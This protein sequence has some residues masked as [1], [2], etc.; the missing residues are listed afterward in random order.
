LPEE[1]SEPA[2]SLKR[3]YEV[4]E[5]ELLSPRLMAFEVANALRYHP[6]I[7]LDAS[8]L[9]LAVTTLGDLSMT[10]DLRPEGWATAFE[11]STGEDISVYDAVYLALAVESEALFVTADVKLMKG[12]SDE[13]RKYVLPLSSFK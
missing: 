2:R 13:P 3:S 8:D 1:G 6:V 7:R 10:V 12:L 9:V 11:L 4:G 5:V